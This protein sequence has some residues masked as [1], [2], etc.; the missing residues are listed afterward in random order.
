MGTVG[1]E[2]HGE[3]QKGHRE[4]GRTLG[5]GQGTVGGEGHWERGGTLEEGQGTVGGEG[6]RGDSTGVETSHNF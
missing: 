5:E 6:H 2:G 1:G 3:G 4:R